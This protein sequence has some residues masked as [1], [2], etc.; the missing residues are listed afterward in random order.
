ML[1]RQIGNA[2]TRIENVGLDEGLSR[3]RFQAQPARA[4]SRWHGRARGHLGVHQE[5]SQE[6]VRS[7]AGHEQHRRLGD[8][9]K[10]AD[11]G[12]GALQKWRRVDTGTSEHGPAERIRDPIGEGSEFFL[13]H[14]VVVAPP[15]VAGDLAGEGARRLGTGGKLVAKGDHDHRPGFGE[16]RLGIVPRPFRKI[17]HGPL[18]AASEPLRE[19][20]AGLFERRHGREAH[21]GKSERQRRVRNR[22]SEGARLGV[23][24]RGPVFRSV[25]PVQAHAI[26][27]KLSRHVPA[28]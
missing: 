24:S 13:H 8:E 20:L 27:A 3:A 21:L 18:V 17:G 5:L 23:P 9:T 14:Q 25:G 28:C 10:S 4:A 15:R 1:D 16:Q 11:L 19:A 12:C 22:F 7:E 2:A 26:W 6:D